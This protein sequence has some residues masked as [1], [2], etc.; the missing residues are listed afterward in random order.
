MPLF[1]LSLAFLSG[2]L[3]G[4]RW[5]LP[6]YAWLLAGASILAVAYLFTRLPW[7]ARLQAILARLTQEIPLLAI[8][9]VF[10]VVALFSGAGR[11]ALARPELS[12]EALAWYND[13]GPAVITGVISAPPELGAKTVTLRIQARQIQTNPS[14]SG[15]RELPVR[16]MLLAQTLPGGDWRYGD[17]VSLEGKPITPQDSSD[18]P[19]RDYLARQG[20]YS[21]ISYPRIDLLRR[22]QGNPFQAALYTIQGRLLQVVDRLFPSPESGLL[23]GILLGVESQI[24]ADVQQAFKNTGTSHIIAISGFNIAILAGLLMTFFSRL[25]GRRGGALAAILGIALYTLLVG[26]SGSVVRAAIMGSLGIFAGQ[27]GRRQAGLNTLGATALTMTLINP[28][29]LWDTGFQLSFMAT[30]GLILYA[31]PFQQTFQRLLTRRLPLET[32]RR[33][34]GP[35]GEYILFTLAAQLT[36]LPIIAY[37]FQRISLISLLANPFVLP[38]QPLVM[39]LGG[40]ATLAGLVYLP[41]GQVLAALAWPFLAYT[42]RM[43]ELFAGIPHG[44]LVLGEVSLVFVVLAYGLLF[45]WTSGGSRLKIVRSVLTPSMGLIALAIL[46]VI[47]WRS[48]LASPD[49]R[50]HITLLGRETGGAVLV[51]GPGGESL[52]FNGGPDANLAAEALGRRLPPFEQSLDALIVASSKR[53]EIAALPRLVKQYPAGLVLWAVARGSSSASRSLDDSLAA[54]QVS[55][56]PA[57]AGQSLSLGSGARLQVL[58]VGESGN[59]WALEW[60]SFRL[61]LAFGETDIPPAGAGGANLLILAGNAPAEGDLSEWVE[62]FNPQLVLLDGTQQDAARNILSNGSHGWLQVATDGKQIWLEAEE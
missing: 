27:L 51:Q 19:Y 60:Q 42:I 31:G 33:I 7:P 35:V 13:Q 34:A 43:V 2:V 18:F 62:H 50:L 14:N 5:Q 44:V 17:L 21:Q 8:A 45:L 30:L 47:T 29:W 54:T 26:A 32:A 52:L 20:I 53:E 22:G 25:L 56:L 24:P 36:T 28:N 39:V 15:S 58:S 11:S 49:G 1:W 6:T 38:P 16:G 59:L 48:A 12:P 3:L 46:A 57:S 9:P 23:A 37:Q 41:L 10:L 4:D 40:L 61:V 55:A